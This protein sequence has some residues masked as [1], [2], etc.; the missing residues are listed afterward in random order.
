MAQPKVCYWIYLWNRTT[1][2]ASTGVGGGGHPETG[3]TLTGPSLHP[4][5]CI[6]PCPYL[7]VFESA[8]CQVMLTRKGSNLLAENICSCR[9]LASFIQ[10]NLERP[11]DCSFHLERVWSRWRDN[12]N[13]V[14]ME[15]P[16]LQAMGLILSSAVEQ[17]ARAS[18][19]LL[20]GQNEFECLPKGS[21]LGSRARA[22]CPAHSLSSGGLS[23]GATGC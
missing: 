23:L 19:R 20:N 22:V 4:H 5:K 18:Q 15:H 7:L 9:P 14:C 13:N 10:E 16:F 17:G 21:L 1:K 2:T 8:L 3:P 11:G 12:N 6:Y